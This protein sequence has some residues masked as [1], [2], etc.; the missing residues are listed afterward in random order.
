MDR[1]RFDGS[2]ENIAATDVT[3]FF[4]DFCL[5]SEVINKERSEERRKVFWSLQFI[6]RAI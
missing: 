4:L 2:S 5:V 6:V 3:L 1:V